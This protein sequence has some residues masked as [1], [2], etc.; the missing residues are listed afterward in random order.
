[1]K[2]FMLTKW[3]EAG[4]TTEDLRQELP[5]ISISEVAASYVQEKQ[6]ALNKSALSSLPAEVYN[7]ATKTAPMY[8]IGIPA[9]AAFLAYGLTHPDLVQRKLRG[10]QRDIIK[11]KIKKHLP[12]PYEEDEED[13]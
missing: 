2:E 1:M 7:F 3:A 8:S 4:L 10:E 11:K 5:K 13:K 9:A 12:P 6:A